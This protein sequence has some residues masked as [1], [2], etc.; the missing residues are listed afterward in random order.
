MKP[1]N[2]KTGPVE[3]PDDPLE[4]ETPPNKKR[5]RRVKKSVKKGVVVVQP[6]KTEKSDEILL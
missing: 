2:T 4:V 1:E 6:P 5:Y 3:W